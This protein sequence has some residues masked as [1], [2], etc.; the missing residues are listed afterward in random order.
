MTGLCGAVGATA[1]HLDALVDDLQH[2]GDECADPFT[3]RRLGVASVRHPGVASE[4]A[5]ATADGDVVVRL[6]GSIWGDDTDDGYVT[7]DDGA[8]AYCAERYQEVGLDFLEGVNGNFAG[9]LYDAE[10]GTLSLFTDRLST[11]PIYLYEGDTLVFST[12]LQSLPLHPAVSTD[13]DVDYL[14]EYFAFKRPYGVKTPLEDVEALHPGSVLTVDVN[15]GTSTTERYWTPHYDP[16]DASRSAFAAKLAETMKTVVDERTDSEET[17]GLLLSGGSDSRLVLAAF[18]ALDEPVRT[19]HLNEWENREA[20]IARRAAEVVGA[21]YEFLQRDETYQARSLESSPKLANFDGYFNQHHAGGFA[22]KLRAEC[23]FLFTGHYGD[24]LFKATHLR[25]PTV[26]L[27]GLG[28]FELPVERPIRGLD[29]YVA[30]RTAPAPEYL[31]T[32]RSPEDIYYDNVVQQGRTVVD[33]GVEYPSLR[34]ATVCSRYPLSNST[35]G[36]FYHATTQMLPAGTPFI[37]NR[38]IDLFLKIPP[39][40]L[41]RG[42]LINRATKLLCPELADLPHGR[43]LV[44]VHYPFVLQWATELG[45]DFVGRHL[46]GDNDQSH[47]SDG[48]WTNHGELVRQHP[49]VREVIDDN[50]E[51]IRALPFLSWEGVQ[52]C[53][54]A[55]ERGEDRMKDLYTLVTFLQMPLLDRLNEEENDA[56]TKLA[57]SVA[58]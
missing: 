12:S 18:D 58:D 6:W 43:S 23:D 51:R 11:R 49:F 7:V 34:E 9:A 48:P 13:L 31:A 44:P 16:V 26:D 14:T 24:T 28:S 37:D 27:G 1:S 10:A 15:D 54:R 22:E 53:Y 45:R 33:H 38:L 46:G 50:E 32:S 5:A 47:W 52:Q 21:E 17:T 30:D 55:H 2:N 57:S 42:N 40:H 8:A 41:V 25:T 4:E 19:Y 36:F 3:D 29:E 35:S 20:Q 56:D 39:K